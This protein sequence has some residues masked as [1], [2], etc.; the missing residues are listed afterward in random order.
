M[1][2]QLQVLTLIAAMGLSGAAN[3]ALVDRGG[4]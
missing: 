4:G 1:N 3:A 2:K